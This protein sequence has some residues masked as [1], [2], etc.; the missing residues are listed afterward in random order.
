MRTTILLMLALLT[1]LASIATAQSATED[2]PN[3]TS[4]RTI[5]WD[6]NKWAWT[7]NPGNKATIDLSGASSVEIGAFT[8]SGAISLDGAVSITGTAA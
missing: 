5:D 6:W 3:H 7:M 4:P 8:M 2:T 1:G